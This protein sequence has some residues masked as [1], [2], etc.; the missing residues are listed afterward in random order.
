[1]LLIIF[2]ISY[3]LEG[4]TLGSISIS[5]FIDVF[6]QNMQIDKSEMEKCIQEM[7]LKMLSLID[8]NVLPIDNNINEISLILIDLLKRKYSFSEDLIEL[9]NMYLAEANMNIVKS[10]DLLFD[11]FPIDKALISLCSVV[12]YLKSYLSNVYDKNSSNYKLLF[13]EIDSLPVEL[14]KYLK[15]ELKVIKISNWTQFNKKCLIFEKELHN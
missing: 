14:F 7:E 11:F 8:Y 6:F 4:N 13:T 15:N 10:E 12:I 5:N 1:M 9:I 2:L 3:K